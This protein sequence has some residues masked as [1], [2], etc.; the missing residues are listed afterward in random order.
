MEGAVYYG[1]NTVRFSIS[2][3]SQFQTPEASWLPLRTTVGKVT[4]SVSPF[5]TLFD[6]RDVD[7]TIGTGNRR[8]MRI[9]LGF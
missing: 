5:W 4:P 7:I 9:N 3:P 8:H 6:I 2:A 1:S